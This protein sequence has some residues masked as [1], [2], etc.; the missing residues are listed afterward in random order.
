MKGAS[1]QPQLLLGS[2]PCPLDWV[3]VRKRLV[4]SA[5]ARWLPGFLAGSSLSGAQHGSEDLLD[6]PHSVFIQEFSLLGAS[7]SALP[8]LV[9]PRY[10]GCIQL[11]WSCQGP[12]LQACLFPGLG[13][14]SP[15]P[16]F[17]FPAS[18]VGLETMTVARNCF[19]P[20]FGNRGGTSAN[21]LCTG[22]WLQVEEM[23]QC[24]EGGE[25][26]TETMGSFVSSPRKLCSAQL[27]GKLTLGAAQSVPKQQL[28]V[29]I[30]V[31]G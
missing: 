15:W 10:G 9:L 31:A 7:S 3:M 11:P 23:L 2:G 26:V 25:E 24:W 30:L 12:V 8:Y 18:L 21:S 14:Q 16:G 17:A 27:L 5:E 29:I 20:G 6:D 1:S 13:R 4:R 19:S 22:L 28:Y